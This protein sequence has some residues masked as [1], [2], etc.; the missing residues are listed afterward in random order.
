[1]TYTPE[2]LRHAAKGAGNIGKMLRA[3]ADA[4]EREREW[5]AAATYGDGSPMMTPARLEAELTTLIGRAQTAR[6]QALEEAA[7]VVDE[8]YG[9]GLSFVIRRIR[10]LKEK[11]D[12]Q[13]I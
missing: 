8:Y 1:M 13:Q 9:G 10:A 2:D 12:G 3:G 11:T 6:N 4:M 5:A 7:G